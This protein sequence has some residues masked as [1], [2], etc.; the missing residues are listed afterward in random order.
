MSYLRN[1]KSFGCAVVF[2]VAGSASTS[3]ASAQAAR[4]QSD[5][6]IVEWVAAPPIDGNRPAAAHQVAAAEACAADNRTRV[7][8]NGECLVIR[9]YGEPAQRTSLVVFIHGDGYRGGPSD[10][11]YKLAR[12]FGAKGVVAVGLIRPGYYDSRG[13]HSTGKS[14]RDKDNYQPDVIATV[15]AAV[16]ALK[17][18]YKAQV[19]VLAGHSGGAAI[20]GVIIG[21]YPGLVDAA[22]LAACPCNVPEWRIMRRGRNNWHLSLSPH[23]FIGKIDKKTTVV[24]VTGGVD[25][26]TVPVLARDYLA[27]LK[28]RGIDATFIEVPGIGHD[29]IV[30][31][32]DYKTAIDR[33]LA[34]RP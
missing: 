5:E 11:M 3:P 1:L 21:R 17:N 24:A 32:R 14:Y 18:H 34:G 12:E 4:A 16:E 15:A 13:N 20:S 8:A 28:G 7:A 26:N 9:A 19:V 31:T 6:T 33:L 23:D 22:V 27:S 10:Y 30:T 25:G 29:D 2:L